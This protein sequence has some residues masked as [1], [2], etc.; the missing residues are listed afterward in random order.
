MFF[1]LTRHS[2]WRTTEFSIHDAPSA[3]VVVHHS[4]FVRHS[5]PTLA[6]LFT[7]PSSS[8]CS[9]SLPLCCSLC[10]MYCRCTR[11]V[12]IPPAVYYA[13]LVA[14]RAQFF[15]NVGDDSS[16]ESSSVVQGRDG[17]AREIDWARCFSS[18]HQSLTNVMYFV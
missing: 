16:S 1:S 18:V 10:F 14:F 4:S 12:S 15:V 9:P 7:P 17:G 2:P 6:S 13:H 3:L 5:V 8:S 11:S